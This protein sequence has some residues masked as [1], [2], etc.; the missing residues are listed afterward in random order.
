[1]KLAQ[2]LQTWVSI[3][4]PDADILGLHNDSRLI[5]P[6]YL[7]FAYPG[8]VADGRL[9]LKQ[10][11]QA[12]AVAIVYEPE[13]VPTSC[14]IPTEVPCFPIT[15]LVTKLAAIASR[16]YD[17]P[18]RALSVTGITGT[19]GKTT[20]AYQLAQAYSLLLKKSAYVGTLGQG[21]IE[22]IQP[23]M[24]TTPDALCL[25][26]LL[27]DYKQSGIQQVCMEVSSHALH[28][29]RVNSIDFTQAI[30]TNLSHD[31]L[32]Y[33]HTMQAYAA[34]KAALFEWPSLTWA[35]INADDAYSSQMMAGVNASCKKLTYGLNE[36]CDVRA[37]NW[38]TTMAGSQFDVQSPWGNHHVQ[39]NLLGAFNVYNSLAVFASLLAA[40]NEVS[41]VLAIMQ[42]LRASPGRMEVVAQKPCVIVDYAHTPD[43]LEKALTTLSQLKQGRLMV[44]F[45]CGGD[46]DKT[47]RPIMGRIASQY[48]DVSIIT[49]DNPRSESPADIIDEIAEGLLAKSNVLKILDRAQAIHQALSMAG[50]EDILLIAGKGHEAYQQIGN[51]RFAFSDQEVVRQW[52]NDAKISG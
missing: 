20:I 34:A 29:G 3:D 48:A 44:V 8:A 14:V 1:M 38:R 32:D 11:I 41:E 46:R 42:Q 15:Q 45:G 21:G 12:G 19:N 23:L 27:Y 17:Y 7:F 16:F 6:G 52:L 22:D 18:S 2:L 26:K 39:V 47:K 49:S 31:H 40:G 35:I 13:Q 51:E 43:A 9:F 37:I 25:Q 10:A 24:N 30:Y 33:H 5:R 36:G 50:Q 28:Q 4:M